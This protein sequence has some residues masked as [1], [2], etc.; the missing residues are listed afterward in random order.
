MFQLPEK[1]TPIPT[2]TLVR[3]PEVTS[4]FDD[5]KVQMEWQ[6]YLNKMEDAFSTAQRYEKLDFP[7]D[8]KIAAWERFMTTF[9][10]DNPYS[11]RDEEFRSAAH[12]R[13]QFWKKPPLPTPVPT[14]FLAP[15][16]MPTPTPLP[17]TPMP[18]PTATPQLP[19]P[20]PQPPT[21]RPSATPQPVFRIND[22]LITD[23]RGKV[24]QPVNGIYALNAGES[25]TIT[26]DVAQS[27]D[28]PI[29]FTWT[30]GQGNLSSKSK[31]TTTYTAK[32]GGG[33]YI[34]IRIKDEK[35]GKMLQKSLNMTVVALPTPTPT[36]QPPTPTPTATPKPP[37]PT[38]TATPQP[39][40]R[41]NDVVIKDAKGKVIQPVD[42][43]YTF[44]VGDTVTM[45]V[46]MTKPEGHTI[47]FTWT[48]GQGKLSSKS[49]PATKY[50]AKK[51]GGDYVLIRIK[52]TKT[53]KTLQKSINI[54]VVPWELQE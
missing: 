12:E 31:P 23:T 15:T 1:P 54:D 35:T 4:S 30:A 33:D 26:V 27:H 13:I 40:F 16:P 8:A 22:V 18:V 29:K 49:K 28:H 3:P 37:T 14:P 38:P 2:P 7:A 52:D 50:T 51:S 21:P 53:G 34:L 10:E 47:K 25:V 48:V 45:M 20:T 17:P 9:S 36:P 11:S 32:E 46:D 39:V 24:I 19:T 6:E 44:K 43:I 42:G 41:I 5:L